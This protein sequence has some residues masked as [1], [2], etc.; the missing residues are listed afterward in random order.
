MC[1]IFG[2]TGFKKEELE[3]ARRSLNTLS[4]RGPDQWGDWYDDNIYIG[5]RRLSIIDLSENAKQPMEDHDIVIAV[6]G[7]IYN[8]KELRKELEAKYKFRSLSDSEVLLHG[9]KEWGIDELLTKID[10][11]FAFCIYD[12]GKKNLYLVRDRVGI[13]PL[14]YSE[15]NGCFAWSSELKALEKLYHKSILELDKTASYDFL[16]YLYIPTPKTYYKNVY[17][18]EP[19]HYLEINLHSY[20]AKKVCYWQL[21]P[22]KKSISLQEAAI[23]LRTL[24]NKSVKEQLVSDVPIGFFLS[25]GIDSS[26]VVAE[27]TKFTENV[28]TFTI[29][30][31]QNKCD[32]FEYAELIAK[33]F[34][35]NHKQKLLDHSYVLNNLNR[36][37][38]WYDEPFADTSAFPTFLVSK[39]SRESSKV[40]LTGDGGDEVFGGYN[41]YFKFSKLQEN[42]FPVLKLL[43][44]PV[45]AL[46]GRFRNLLI[47]KKA[48]RLENYLLCDDLV[49]YTKL[50]GGM[51]K[52]E[53]IH[54]SKAWEIPKDY[55]DYWYFRKYY[56]INL[57]ILTRLQ[58]LDFHTYLHDDILTKVDR[59]S[60]AVSLEARVPL[61]SKE[62]I[63]F[64][65]SIPYKLIFHGNT[66]KG[67]LKFAYKDILPDI[68]LNRGKRGFSI[69]HLNRVFHER[70]GLS[71]QESILNKLYQECF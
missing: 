6:N 39:F 26:I 51:L 21:K 67:L 12:R 62:I 44:P 59:V 63:E 33:H 56:R 42:Q 10:G 54:Y 16:T 1:G 19:A 41:W 15:I 13:K 46:K 7:E 49:L 2:Y 28:H 3:K 57:P 60:M 11:M 55:D 71:K 65:F 4:H 52:E 30:F 70:F 25:G 43:K 58:F 9:Y 53:K 22:Q 8:F 23:S 37:K 38:E 64:A 68:I 24:I 31:G 40:V 29:G 32:E 61:L 27:A 36:L 5:H 20:T 66:L 45:S 48:N 14:Y 34:N 47:G 18:L 69:P 50:M 17:K 35:T